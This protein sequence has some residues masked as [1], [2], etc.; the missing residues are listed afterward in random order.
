MIDALVM[1]GKIVMLSILSGSSLIDW[2]KVVFNTL[3]LKCIHAPAM[4]ET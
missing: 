1:G 2:T 4:F 3:A